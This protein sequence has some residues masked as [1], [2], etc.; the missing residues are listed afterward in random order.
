MGLLFIPLVSDFHIES[1]IIAAATGAFWGGISGSETGRSKPDLRCVMEI[2][3]AL[4]LLGLPL[5]FYAVV[6]GCYTV[7]GLGFWLFLPAPS[8]FLG[9]GTGRLFRLFKVPFPRFLTLGTL[10]LIAAG[11]L[12]YEF[13]TLPQLYFFNHV[14]GYW[15][16]PIYDEAVHFPLSLVGFRFLTLCWVLLVW[17]IPVLH[18]DRFYKW[19]VGLA[20]LGLVLG[21]TQLEQMGIVTPREYLQQQLGGVLETEHARLYYDEKAFSPS[22]IDRLGMETEFYV[23]QVQ[24]ALEIEQPDSANPI[25]LY[26]YADPWQKKQLVGAKYTSYVTV[27]QR[28]PQVHIARGQVEGT[29]KHEIVHAVTALLEW[30]GLVPNIGLTEGIAVA[31]A[32][33]RSP[34]STI[35]QLV[36]AGGPY[37]NAEQMESSLSYWGFYTSRSPVSYTTAGSFVRYLIE[38]YPPQ[39]FVNAYKCG[40]VEHGYE[41]PF[42]DLVAGWH[43]RLD[44]VRIDSSD[45]RRASDMFGRPSVFEQPCPHKVSRAAELFDRFLLSQTRGDTAVALGALTEL[46]R[47]DTT[48]YSSDLLWMVWNLK[49]GTP[50]PVIR[51]A[52]LDPCRIEVQLLTADACQLAGRGEQARQH[53]NRAMELATQQS[54]TTFEEAFVVRMDSLQWQYD[55]QLRFSESLLDSTRFDRAYYRLKMRTVENLLQT[56]EEERDLLR[57]YAARLAALPVD[58]DYFSTYLSMIHHLGYTGNMALAERWIRK[59]NAQKLSSRYRERLQQQ[60]EWIQYLSRNS[61]KI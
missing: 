14:W 9:Y 34:R 13:F 50:E 49:A 1:A 27:W 52:D 7:H 46:R 29:L 31:L 45:R 35:D 43:H 22:E 40:D 39:H 37:P 51:E 3:A 15:P 53:L 25:E 23:S 48:R 18:K 24:K 56:A 26:L 59:L 42:A 44:S 2:L 30:P 33:D 36:A 6:T 20:T 10:S 55:L 17:L 12:L 57:F 8:V 19:I 61:C 60:R 11:G 16:G 58:M 32:P 21:Y 41:R 54:D 47:I 5:L 28:I 4:Y 38:T